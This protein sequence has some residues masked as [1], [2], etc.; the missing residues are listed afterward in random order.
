[1][2]GEKAMMKDPGLIF[3]PLTAG[4]LFEV[5]FSWGVNDWGGWIGTF[6]FEQILPKTYLWSLYNKKILIGI[7]N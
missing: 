5:C 6:K 4:P 2:P 7:R 1:M 3:D